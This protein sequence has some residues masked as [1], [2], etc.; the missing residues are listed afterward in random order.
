[1]KKFYILFLLLPFQVFSQI[2]LNWTDTL[3]VNRFT[4]NAFT[5]PKIALTKNNVP[6]VMW[7]RKPN[8]R[9]FV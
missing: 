6:V 8:Q 4:P 3:V 7:G 2:S 5:R 9:V 1:M